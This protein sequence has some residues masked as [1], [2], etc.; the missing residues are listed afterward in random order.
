MFTLLVPGTVV[1]YIPYRIIKAQYP[2][3]FIYWDSLQIISIVFFIIGAA[4][5]FSCLWD[6]AITGR[7]TPAPIDAPKHLVI[8]NLYCYVRNPMYIGVLFVL[9][10]WS[11]L[12][13]SFSVFKFALLMATIFHCF[14]MFF[15]EPLLRHQFGESYTNYC[16]AVGRWLPGKKYE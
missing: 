10:G 15:E 9:L 8:K 3:F 1:V 12:Y 7:A 6:F 4:I 5:Y 2:S 14:I 13:A 16:R 11:L